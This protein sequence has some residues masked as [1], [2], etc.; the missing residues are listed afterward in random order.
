VGEFVK[1]TEILMTNISKENKLCYLM[2]DFNLMNYNCHQF[3]NEF[4]DIMN[5][6][7]FFPL[8]TYPTRITSYTAMLIDNIFTNHLESYSFSGL[9]FTDI[10]DH[11]PVF[12]V[13]YD[14]RTYVDKEAYVVYRDKNKTN[15]AKFHDKLQNIVWSDL[16]EY[17]DPKHAYGSFFNT[18][19]ETI[20]VSIEKSKCFQVWLQKALKNI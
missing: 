5:S 10:S 17:N 6:N 3:T 19:T 13:L 11:L 8:I 16:P 20:I 4:M 1:S 12:C 14:Q 2:G 15:I 9:L 18:F 7:M